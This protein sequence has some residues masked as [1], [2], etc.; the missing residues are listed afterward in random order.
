MRLADEDDDEGLAFADR[1]NSRGNERVAEVLDRL[2][3]MALS[4]VS[5]M[6]LVQGLRDKAELRQLHRALHFWSAT[7]IHVDESIS[8]RA[9]FLMEQHALADSLQVADA[10]IAATAVESGRILLTG[11]VKHYERLPGITVESFRP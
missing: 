6:E 7:I 9:S 11:S 4:A 8:S 2:P 5:Y 10:L 3:D 1:G